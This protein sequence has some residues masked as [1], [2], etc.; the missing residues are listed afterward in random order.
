MHFSGR[1]KC[2][3]STSER[4]R[5]LTKRGTGWAETYCAPPRISFTAE[6]RGTNSAKAANGS[7]KSSTRRN[8]AA[9]PDGLECREWLLPGLFDQLGQSRGIDQHQCAAAALQQPGAL[10]A[11]KFARDRF[12][13]G[14]DASRQFDVGWW[15]RDHGFGFAI[16]GRPGEAQ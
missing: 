8:S 5:C 2:T 11:L 3:M 13:A 10:Q 9:K 1:S 6:G 7:N 15:W 16:P 12:A 4:Y 14:A